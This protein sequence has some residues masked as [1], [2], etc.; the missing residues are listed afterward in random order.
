M[1]GGNSTVTIGHAQA[2]YAQADG[3]V[4]ASAL[5][6]VINLMIQSNVKTEFENDSYLDALVLTEV[7]F[8]RSNNSIKMFT[9][10]N[11]EGFLKTLKDSFISAAQRL[12]AVKGKVRILMISNKVPDS[13]QELKSKYP[14]TLE[15]ALAQI[16]EGADPISHFFVCDSKMARVE[17]P[18]GPLDPGTPINAI[19]ARVF[20]NDVGLAKMLDGKFSAMW[21]VIHPAQTKSTP[22][23]P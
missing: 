22:A 10:P 3:V 17:Q 11:C 19:K 18:H 14:D 15:I 13:L 7:M 9:G 23:V 12:N 20:F 16:K 8:A 2:W 1:T 4:R 21:N 5:R 6:E